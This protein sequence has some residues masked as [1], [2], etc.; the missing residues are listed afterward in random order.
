MKKLSVGDGPLAVVLRIGAF[1]CLL[2]TA[3]C[4]LS[5]SIPNLETAQCSEA[6]DSVKEFYSWYSGTESEDRAK[7]P[8]VFKKYISSESPLN[9]AGGE[10]IDPFF[11]SATPPTTFKIGKCEMVDGTH[12]NIQV[13]L[14]WRQEAKTD[15]REVYADTVKS[16]DRWQIEKIESR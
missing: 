13:Q 1:V 14:Y 4:Q 7:Q 16:G 3:Y 10:K 8:E 11:N 5:C 6:R 9:S 2:P 15:Q 12:T